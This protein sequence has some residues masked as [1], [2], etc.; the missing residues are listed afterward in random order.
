MPGLFPAQHSWEGSALGGRRTLLLSGLLSCPGAQGPGA[1]AQQR[2]GLHLS[3]LAAV[4]AADLG[5]P[6]LLISSSS[7]VKVQG[8]NSLTQEERNIQACLPRRQEQLVV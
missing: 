7:L 6:S 2:E 3:A 5:L 4:W 1:G 8:G